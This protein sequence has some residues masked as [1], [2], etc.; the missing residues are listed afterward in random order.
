MG[1]EMI[2]DD[3]FVCI[4]HRIGKSTLLCG[5]KSTGF[6]CQLFV[7]P[8]WYCS[9]VTYALIIVLTIFFLVNAAVPLGPA[10]VVLGSISLIVTV[11]FFSATACSDP[12]IIFKYVTP[13]INNTFEDPADH[14]D[15]DDDGGNDQDI[16]IAITSGNMDN[17]G[18]VLEERQGPG[19]GHPPVTPPVGEEQ[20]AMVPIDI[21]NDN[22]KDNNQTKT[23][24]KTNHDSNSSGSLRSGKPQYVGV[25]PST[26]AYTPYPAPTGNRR[27]DR[28]SRKSNGDR[29]S[30]NAR[31]TNGRGGNTRGGSNSNNRGGGGGGGGSHIRGNTDSRGRGGL[32]QSG[33]GPNGE[34]WTME[35]SI[36]QV[37]TYT[38]HHLTLC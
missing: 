17:I 33:I 21:I 31:N 29:N 20:Q 10:V 35:C 12:G 11:M 28:A 26:N 13:S 22:D 24:N 19:H 14:N 6:P 18:G 8:E 23:E 36:C 30:G 37:D 4:P 3:Q 5:K 34:I 9:F 15:D 2:D 25:V 32:A 7:G 38:S 27:G 16:E 1:E